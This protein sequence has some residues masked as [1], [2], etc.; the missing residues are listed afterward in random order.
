VGSK[1]WAGNRTSSYGLEKHSAASRLI[2]AHAPFAQSLDGTE[3]FPADDEGPDCV[4]ARVLIVFA[5]GLSMVYRKADSRTHGHKAPWIAAPWLSTT[6]GALRARIE[7]AL[8]L[9]A[10]LDRERMNKE[11][12]ATFEGFDSCQ[13]W[14]VR[15]AFRAPAPNLRRLF[16]TPLA[17][18]VRLY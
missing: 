6:V 5:D 14:V 13:K 16:N 18:R 1:W 4:L 11:W 12:R 7:W 3:S 15:G 9:E 2:N 10:C 17:R 8:D